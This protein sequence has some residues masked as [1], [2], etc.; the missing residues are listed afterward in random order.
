MESERPLWCAKCHLEIVSADLRTVCQRVDYHR[1][2]FLLLV[3]EEAEEQIRRKAA[4]VR[5]VE[6]TVWSAWTK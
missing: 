2:C 1:H 5:P 4:R 3:R 6:Q